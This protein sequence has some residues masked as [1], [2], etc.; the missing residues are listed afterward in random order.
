MGTSYKNFSIKEAAYQALERRVAAELRKNTPRHPLLDVE[1]LEDRLGV[2]IFRAIK[3]DRRK[4]I[5]KKK[6]KPIYFTEDMWMNDW[7][8]PTYEGEGDPNI[9]L[10]ALAIVPF[11]SPLP[12]RNIIGKVFEESFLPIDHV[13]KGLVRFVREEDFLKK[14]LEQA[15]FCCL[16]FIKYGTIH[17]IFTVE[18]F[19]HNKKPFKLALPVA[20]LP[21]NNTATHYDFQ[22]LHV[23]KPTGNVPKPYREGYVYPVLSKRE[24]RKWGG[25]IRLNALVV[26]FID[27]SWELHV[28]GDYRKGKRY[29]RALE[30][31]KGDPVIKGTQ[32]EEIA[33]AIARTSFETMF[34]GNNLVCLPGSE[35]GDYILR[36]KD[37]KIFIISSANYYFEKETDL[38]VELHRYLFSALRNRKRSGITDWVCAMIQLL[39][40]K[41]A[42][43]FED[44]PLRKRGRTTYIFKPRNLVKGLLMA[45]RKAPRGNSG[46]LNDTAF[47]KAFW[48]LYYALDFMTQSGTRKCRADPFLNS[49]GMFF[50]KLKPLAGRLD[51]LSHSNNSVKASK[52]GAYLQGLF[53]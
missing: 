46:G 30:P 42:R 16:D 28:Q 9:G 53:R 34:Y 37:G 11:S 40:Q 18:Y 45:R 10:R 8:G 3:G 6:V 32:A 51:A 27:D 41:E 23:L 1:F 25:P 20:G 12:N 36:K 2:D 5:R 31:D 13:K 14:H 48:S 26:E 50:K 15:Q 24:Q 43:F 21:E 29:F 49:Y 47:L 7:D 22:M 35:R 17:G 19:F 44:D 4:N 38:Y 33:D 39:S 52:A